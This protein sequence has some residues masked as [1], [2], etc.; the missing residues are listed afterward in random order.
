MIITC[1]KCISYNIYKA[2]YYKTFYSGDS[3]SYVLLLS[4]EN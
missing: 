3:K 2:T 4:L 1:C